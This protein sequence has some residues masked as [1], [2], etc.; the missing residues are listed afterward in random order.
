M[1]APDGGSGTGGAAAPAA[2]TAPSTGG[3]TE[4]AAWATAARCLGVAVWAA[5]A[6]LPRQRVEYE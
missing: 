3:G 2:T 4:G 1:P 5:E 6:D